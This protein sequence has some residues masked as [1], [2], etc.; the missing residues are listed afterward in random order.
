MSIPRRSDPQGRQGNPS[1]RTGKKKRESGKTISMIDAVHMMQPVEPPPPPEAMDDLVV[2]VKS[3]PGVG[4]GVLVRRLYGQHKGTPV[5]YDPS[6]GLVILNREEKQQIGRL[7]SPYTPADPYGQYIFQ[8]PLLIE[9]AETQ[10]EAVARARATTKASDRDRRKELFQRLGGVYTN[11]KT[12]EFSL[13][14]AIA[15]AKKMTAST[16]SGPGVAP[17][18]TLTGRLDPARMTLPV[19][20]PDAQADEDLDGIHTRLGVWPQK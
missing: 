18:R 2:E 7:P 16:K 10:A 13:T 20:D 17:K 4:K 8:N 19:I 15:A 12:L 3:V 1:A 6:S 5:Y 14:K 9:T 11:P